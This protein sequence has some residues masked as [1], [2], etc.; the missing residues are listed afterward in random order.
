MKEGKV[1]NKRDLLLIKEQFLAHGITQLYD[2][3]H[4]SGIGKEAKAIMSPEIQV[5]SA[6]SAIYKKGTYG[7]FLG[8][9]IAS[10][11]EVQ[12]V[13]KRLYDSGADFIKVINSGIIDP[14]AT[15]GV[16]EGGFDEET[17]K[18][19][20][21]CAGDLNLA[22]RTHANGDKAVRMAILHGTQTIEHGIFISKD[23]VLLMKEKDVAWVP[24]AYAFYQA[25]LSLKGED[26]A[27]ELLD[28]HLEN[29]AYAKDI[30]VRVLVGSDS[31]GKA[32]P[33]C[34][35]YEKEKEL[36]LRAGV[37]TH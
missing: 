23:T 3:G 31:G 9:A 10:K 25:M 1:M 33:H 13:I 2:M 32:L 27:K 18:E 4:K 11:K 15:G 7:S 20:F 34:V 12:P 19:I 16:T 28:R 37:I 26:T 29:I 36:L 17:L 8:I 35:A 21:H 6:I 22:I 5:F 14:N 24:T 30:G